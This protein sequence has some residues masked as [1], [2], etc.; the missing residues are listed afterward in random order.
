MWLKIIMLQ[1]SII[2]SCH[3]ALMIS[4]RKHIEIMKQVGIFLHELLSFLYLQLTGY[5][6]QLLSWLV[7]GHFEAKWTAICTLF[8]ADLTTLWWSCWGSTSIEFTTNCIP[9][10]VKAFP[11]VLPCLLSLLMALTTFFIKVVLEPGDQ[12]PHYSMFPQR[13]AITFFASLLPH[14]RITGRSI[15]IWAMIQFLSF[16]SMQHHS[17]YDIKNLNEL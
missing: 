14:L 17:E 4:R 2:I 13:K 11:R 3:P 6:S 12:V 5:F 9:S 7:M 1:V 15:F 10:S 16:P 8:S